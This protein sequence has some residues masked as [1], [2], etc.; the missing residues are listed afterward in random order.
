MAGEGFLHLAI[1]Q[2]KESWIKNILNH[3]R[4]T[5]IVVFS[6][7]LIFSSLYLNNRHKS[8]CLNKSIQVSNNYLQT[9]GYFEFAD[10]SWRNANGD[11]PDSKTE[12]E[13][14]KYQSSIYNKCLYFQ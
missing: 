14:E 4:L 5:F 2:I 7:L 11:Y 1:E 10:H 9:K 3:K 6:L 12:V 8:F 13:D